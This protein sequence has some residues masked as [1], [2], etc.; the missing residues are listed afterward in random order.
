MLS[1]ELNHLNPH[2]YLS[3]VFTHAPTIVEAPGYNEEKLGRWE[4]LLLRNVKPDDVG[5]WNPTN[6]NA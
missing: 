2:A 5:P 6:S 4:P 3:Y 1:A